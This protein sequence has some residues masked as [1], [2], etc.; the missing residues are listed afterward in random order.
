VCGAAVG[1]HGVVALLLA[2][3]IREVVT[4]KSEDIRWLCSERVFLSRG[5]CSHFTK[6]KNGNLVN[7]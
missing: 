7:T 6:K 4:S 1:F 2:S 5:L 3:F